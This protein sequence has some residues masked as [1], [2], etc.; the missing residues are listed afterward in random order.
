MTLTMSHSAARLSSS[1]SDLVKVSTTCPL[2][3]RGFPSPSYDGFGFLWRRFKLPTGELCLLGARHIH[4][5][6]F[7]HWVTS[8][9]EVEWLM[10]YFVTKRQKSLYVKRN[11]LWVRSGFP[12]ISQECR[13]KV[14]CIMLR[15]ALTN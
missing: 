5:E 8:W 6:M 11:C 2:K 1:N 4:F 12:H 15:V 13:V 14:S 9:I 10:R 7:F 3:T